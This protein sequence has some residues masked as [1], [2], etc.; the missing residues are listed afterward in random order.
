MFAKGA[1][2]GSPKRVTYG[3]PTPETHPHLLRPN[4]VT[5]G[6]KREDYKQRRD[7]Y[8][9]HMKPDTI[10]M[11]AA[12]PHH[13]MT[14]DIPYV[15]RQNSDFYYLTGFEEPESLLILEKLAD[16]QSRTT[17]FVG[18]K[19]PHREMWDGPRSGVQGAKEIFGAEEAFHTHELSAEIPRILQQTK[20]TVFYDPQV[21]PKFTESISQAMNR[22]SWTSPVGLVE[23]L[24]L[25]KSIPEQNIMR[26]VADIAALSMIEA[27]KF[28]KPGMSEAMI[29]AKMEF[30]CRMR[31]ARRLSYPPVVAGGINANT[32]HYIT[33]DLLLK[34][35]DLLLVD[36]GAEYYNYSSDITRVWPVSGKFSGPQRELYEIVLDANLK[37]IKKVEES[38]QMSITQLQRYA[39]TILTTSLKNIGIPA[40]IATRAY[41]HNIGHWLGMDV[42]DTKSIHESI[43]LQPGMIFTI[44]PGVYI[45]DEPE[46]PQHYRGI[47]IR[48]EDDVLI[49]A[50]RKVEVLTHL[51]PKDADKIEEI[52]RQ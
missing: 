36:A 44:E 37:C 46:V 2:G 31:S 18:E 1:F 12:N 33:N 38:D 29:D 3:Q 27:M 15:Y 8:L 6:M 50:D 7:S 26:K 4:E 25:I 39:S 32:I 21:N 40:R 24:R 52:M 47:G 30:E 10:S 9:S 14:N 19:D 13:K 28:T 43:S 22:T 20:G 35:E 51:V 41:P 42:H 11:F 5:P 34:A 16:G 45:P 23:K 49:T 17:M 48:V